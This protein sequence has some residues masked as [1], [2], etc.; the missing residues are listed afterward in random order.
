MSVQVCRS[1]QCRFSADHVPWPSIPSTSRF[2][3]TS[4]P[5]P[6]TCANSDFRSETLTEII[7]SL[8]S[9]SRLRF[10]YDCVRS[11][12][13]GY[14]SLQILGNALAIVLQEFIVTYAE[15]VHF[16][17]VSYLSIEDGWRRNG[18]RV[19]S[20]QISEHPNEML[21]IAFIYNKL[22]NV[23]ETEMRDVV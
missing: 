5:I 3:R 2:C 23:I 14:Y 11:V 22:G 7:H 15:E 10:S 21:H 9:L 13:L 8:S 18:D 17:G 1:P 16:E 19:E 6:Q 20:A 12:S 4:S